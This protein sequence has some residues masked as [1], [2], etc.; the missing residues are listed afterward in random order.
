MHMGD[1]KS[2][3]MWRYLLY[4]IKKINKKNFENLLHVTCHQSP[5][6]PTANS[7]RTSPANSHNMHN[8]LLF[9]DESVCLG[10]PFY[11]K[12]KD[13]KS[14]KKGFLSFI[15]AI[16]SSFISLQSM[17]FQTPNNSVKIF[18]PSKHYCFI[19]QELTRP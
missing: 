8:R 10:E 1:T 2:F 14:N 17:Q 11:L 7:H 5:F 6:T 16:C 3:N 4:T 15:I 12:R 19:K 13:F 9:Q 18:I